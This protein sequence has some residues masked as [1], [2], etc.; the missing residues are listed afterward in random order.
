MS[1]ERRHGRGLKCCDVVKVKGDA[2]EE[3]GSDLQR[4]AVTIWQLIGQLLCTG[5]HR[6]HVTRARDQTDWIE[7]NKVWMSGNMRH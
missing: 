4:L 5:S 2:D 6:Q 7:E 1:G 3:E